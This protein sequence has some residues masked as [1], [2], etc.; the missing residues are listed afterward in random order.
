MLTG[1]VLTAMIL[2]IDLVLTV[3][4]YDTN[5]D[6][7]AAAFAIIGM[8]GW[9]LFV[10]AKSQRDQRRT[11]GIPTLILGATTRG[12]ELVTKMFEDPKVEYKPIGF[13]DDYQSVKRLRIQGVQVLGTTTHLE[14]IIYKTGAKVL[15]S[16]L[17][18]HAAQLKEY[19]SRCRAL[20]V[21]L[22]VQPSAQEIVGGAIRLGDLSEVSE[23]DL[24]G[25]R[26]VKAEEEEIHKMLHGKRI[27]ITGAGGS[28]GSECA[29]Q[30]HLYKPA[31]LGMLDHDE[32]NLH[33]TQ[34]SIEGRALLDT[35]ELILADIRDRERIFEIME[36]FKPDVIIHAA[37]LKHV[38]FLQR[39]PE[40][41][42]KTNVHGTLNLLEAAAANNVS[43]FV[44]ISTDKAADP[45]N[46]LGYSKHIAERLTAGINTNS[47]TNRYLSVRFGNVLG[48]RGSM[49]PA[50]R[51]MIAAGGPVTVTDPEV[52]RY[53]MTIPEA[54]HLVLQAA[55][56]GENG[57]TLILDMGV[58]V[59]I[60]DVAQE[61]I[62]HSGRNIDIVYT[63]LRDGEKLH[64]IL[65][66]ENE[67]ATPSRHPLI[68][69]VMAE[70]LDSNIIPKK[71]T[72]GN[73]ITLL[74]TLAATTSTP[75]LLPR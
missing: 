21:K 18:L 8:I 47:A 44:N 2:T 24:L 31:F 49:L 36:Q 13:I 16:A 60:A 42:F 4:A 1:V 34:M 6:I 41:A 61:L 32:S 23:E 35:D 11:P 46:A 12:E 38:T 70:K 69:Y 62:N 52:T 45:S 67:H 33:S 63:G 66:S 39:S 43:T 3:V 14:D 71:T 64:E 50:F 56:L 37:A 30:V 57:Q 25:R 7:T 27:L 68:N 17:P 55:T 5:L 73:A 48:S 59:K 53:F 15:V 26:P 72:P 75:D 54:V 29:R 10:R 74:K 51:A 28:I 9:R 65:S 19:E 20:N 22:R 40:E 58:P